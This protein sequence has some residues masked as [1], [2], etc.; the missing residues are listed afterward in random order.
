MD[1]LSKKQIEA[2]LAAIYNK[3]D[4]NNLLKTWTMFTKNI[5]HYLKLEWGK[6]NPPT[7][8]EISN[9]TCSFIT[10]VKNSK[11]PNLKK[12]FNVLSSTE[13]EILS[14]STIYAFDS[15]INP[16]NKEY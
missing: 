12:I 10:N 13:I 3:L 6:E 5:V 14:I 4:Q 8:N 9:T 2:Y 15:V 7:L 11:N 16:K 1:E